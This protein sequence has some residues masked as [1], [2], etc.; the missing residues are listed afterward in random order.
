MNKSKRFMS[1]CASALMIF[2]VFALPAEVNA[3]QPNREYSGLVLKTDVPPD[4][5]GD[6]GRDETSHIPVEKVLINRSYATVKQGSTLKLK[7]SVRP[8]SATNQNTYW[9]SSNTGVATISSDG[10]LRAK[11][12]GKTK[13]TLYSR[14]NRQISAVCEITVG[15]PVEQVIMKEPKVS[16]REGDTLRL[17]TVVNPSNASNRKLEWSSSK[18]AVV[19]VKPNGVITAIKPGRAVIT[20]KAQDGTKKA[21]S[22]I[23]VGA[24]VSGVKISK[25]TASVRPGGTIKLKA[26]V[27]PKNAYNVAVRW[28]SSNPRIAS[29]TKEGV[30]TAHKSGNVKITA[31]TLDGR[32]TAF[33]EVLVTSRIFDGRNKVTSG[34]CLP[35]RPNH[36]GIDI[37]GMDSTKVKST[38]SG[39]VRWARAV[40][41]GAPG[42]GNTWEWG[43][44]VWIEATDGTHHIFAHMAAQPDVVEGQMVQPGMAL[45]IMGNTGYSFGAHT[46]YE[47]RLG[48]R[49]TSI[50]PSGYAGVPNAAGIY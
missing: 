39:R 1:L 11:K 46:H 29:I 42:W 28:K 48:D 12:N 37:V 32:K 43:Y 44:F 5:Q 20:A 18:P 41:P 40:A 4:T 27:A 26:I 49:R 50:D 36:Y 13:I 22:T 3:A 14:E 33:C 24:K 8:S 2:S 45:G 34:Y 47:V 9:R 15:T 35:S 6:E 30:I 31:T 7:A 38:V 25:K 10:T 21:V 19:S 16:I 17:K 23:I